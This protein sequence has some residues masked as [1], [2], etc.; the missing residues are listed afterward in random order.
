[1]CTATLVDMQSHYAWYSRY[2]PFQFSAHRKGGAGSISGHGAFFW[3]PLWYHRGTERLSIIMQ[4]GRLDSI[5]PERIRQFQSD[6]V[7]YLNCSE[8]PSTSGTW[9]RKARRKD[10]NLG[11]TSNTGRPGSCERYTSSNVTDWR[12]LGM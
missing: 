8:K 1:M 10:L 2:F 9:P 6:I 5:H 7:P 3:V 11:S 4:S 12:E